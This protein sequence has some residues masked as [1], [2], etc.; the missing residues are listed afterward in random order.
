MPHMIKAPT[1][2]ELHDKLCTRLAYSTRDHLDYVTG[3]DVI[4]SHVFGVADRMDWQYDL[5][6][7]WVPPSR[8][9]TMIRQ[10]VDPEEV[11][12][13]L[14]S[15]ES[16]QKKKAANT[17][18]L[19]TNTV[20]PRNG[21]K[22]TVRNLGSCML[23]V[24]FRRE[25]RPVI[26]LHSRTC[27]MGYLSPLD[28]SVAYHLGRLAASALSL[29]LESVQFA[30]FLETV[31]FHDFRTIAFLLAD[32]EEQDRFL[33]LSYKP[34]D[35]VGI[36]RAREHYDLWERE[37]QDGVPYEDMR[38]FQSYRRLRKRMNTELYGYDFA[39]QFGPE[40]MQKL[41]ST[42]V[43]DLTFEQIGLE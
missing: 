5:Q 29:P 7:V 12:R 20:A 27:Y 4:L 25:P 39:R 24:T 9:T 32:D 23:S 31:Q 34:G 10:Y 3:S 22:G 30:W 13:W 15:I 8:W 21:G 36:A 35:R 28:M 19:R 43:A 2:H 33:R 11:I 16:R 40:A 14:T 37:N 41:P 6:R 1:M 18:V 38:G 42:P 17:F 26:T